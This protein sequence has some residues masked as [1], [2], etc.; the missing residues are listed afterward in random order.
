MLWAVTQDT[1]SLKCRKDE[2][3]AEEEYFPGGHS[4]HMASDSEVAPETAEAFPAMHLEHADAPV[5]LE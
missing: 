2:E 5:W 4:E 3:P 1:R